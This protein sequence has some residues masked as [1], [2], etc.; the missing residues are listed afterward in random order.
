[1]N[2]GEDLDYTDAL[3]IIVKEETDGSSDELYKEDI[4]TWK[5]LNYNNALDIRVKEEETDDGSDEQYKEDITTSNCLDEGTRRQEGRLISLDFKVDG[6]IPQEAYKEHFYISNA[7]LAFQNK[8]NFSPPTKPVPSSDS[9]LFDKQQ[10]KRPHLCSE[11]GKCFTR[12]SVLVKHLR[13]HTGEKPFLCSECGKSFIQKSDLVIHQRRHTGEKPFSCLECG[14]CF[15]VKSRLAEHRILHTGQKP[16]PCAECG[17]SFAVKSR[18]V[19]HQRTH[20]REKTF[21][22]L[23]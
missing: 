14:K 8:H 10:K 17:K 7:F 22:C 2:Q 4:T 5:D 15:I 13:I 9:S 18:L 23:E 19:G 12:K 16:F 3:D 1:M 6:F 21:L 11:C 20:T